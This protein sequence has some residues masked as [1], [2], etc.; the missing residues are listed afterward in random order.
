MKKD[1]DFAGMVFFHTVTGE[2]VNG[3]QMKQ[4]KV[5]GKLNWTFP[6]ARV[7]IDISYGR[8]QETTCEYHDVWVTWEQ[9]TDYYTLGGTY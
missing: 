7:S 1:K 8:S 3:W 4:G 9:C 2:F 5:T 6:E